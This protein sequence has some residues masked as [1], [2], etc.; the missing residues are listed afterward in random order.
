MAQGMTDAQNFRDLP[1]RPSERAF[2]MLAAVAKYAS[3]Q[4]GFEN[5]RDGAGEVLTQLL[6]DAMHLCDLDGLN[7]KELLGEAERRFREDLKPP[8]TAGRKDG[9]ECPN[10]RGDTA[11]AD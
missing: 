11:T 2:Q 9:E 5:W 1:M 6:R 4:P 8:A 10:K 7:F 3:L